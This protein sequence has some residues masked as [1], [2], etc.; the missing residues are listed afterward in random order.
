MKFCVELGPKARA[1]KFPYLT[2]QTWDKDILKW[3]DCIAEV[4]VDLG[5]A[6]RKVY[7]KKK[8]VLKLYESQLT[9]KGKQ[10]MIKT[11]EALAAE[12]VPFCFHF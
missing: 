10:N 8:E 3:N 4:M 2:L 7:E 11:Q 1:S 9:E 6:F 5:A 12:Q